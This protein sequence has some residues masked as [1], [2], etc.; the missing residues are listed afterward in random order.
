MIKEV[1]GKI[2]I[3]YETFPH[4]I[5]INNTETF[6]KIA[7]ESNNYFMNVGSTANIPNSDKQI[8][9][10][11]NTINK[12]NLTEQEFQ[13][14]FQNIKTN[15]ASGFNDIT[16]NVIKSVYDQLFTPLFRICDMSLK[17]GCFPDK[18]KVAKIEPLYKADEMELVSNYRPLS[19]YYQFFQNC[20][21]E[22]YITK[23]TT[24]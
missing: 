12:T 1:I 13:D 8:N 7:N 23:F 24:M 20:Y 4:K 11:N 16:S 2:K 19:I 21:K 15:K 22:Y 3:F 9:C 5:T 10:I 17:F 6:K 14:A 18:M